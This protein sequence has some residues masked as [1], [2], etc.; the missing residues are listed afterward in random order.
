MRIILSGGGTAGHINPAIAIANYFKSRE[1]DC[2]ILFIGTPGGM[3]C[4]LVER[5]GYPMRHIKVTGLKRSLSLD[6]IKT[7]KN[8]VTS[9]SAAKKIIK[10][11]APDAVIGT[12]GYV[13][14]PVMFAAA[15]YKIPTLVHEQNVIPGLTVKM[16]ANCVDVTAISFEETVQ[17]LKKVRRTELVGNPIRNGIL[18]AKKTENDEPVVLISGGSLGADSI[19]NALVELLGLPGQGYYKIIASVGQRNYDKI[20]QKIKEAGI[21]PGPD[22][23]ILPYIYNMDEVLAMAD[24]AITRAGA[25]TVSELCAIGKPAIIIPSPNVAHNHQLYNARYMEKRGAAVVILE[26]ELTGK[27]LAEQIKKLLSDKELLKKMSRAGKAAAITTSCEGIYNIM[28][29]LIIKRG[30]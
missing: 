4:G 7:L 23:E 28:K 11:F 18:S 3:E 15:H 19:N 26:E 5:E 8:A 14:A 30:K 17:Y 22:K 2:E 24:V 1:P 12:G 10:E 25:I 20:M 29:E 13:C 21:T 9:Y 27:L 16:L 6:T